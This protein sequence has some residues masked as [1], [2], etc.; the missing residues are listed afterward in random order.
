MTDIFFFSSVQEIRQENFVIQPKYFYY[1][2]YGTAKSTVRIDAQSKI[3]K[4]LINL[5]ITEKNNL[6]FLRLT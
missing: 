4:S 2:M 1:L 5:K 3:L 6:E